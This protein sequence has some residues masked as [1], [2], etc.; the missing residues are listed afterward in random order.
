M[1][2]PP[3]PPINTADL[4]Q[5][6]RNLLTKMTIALGAPGLIAAIEFLTQ[7]T[8]RD[9][10]DW[11]APFE[12]FV[13]KLL[14]AEAAKLP[15][16]TDHEP[17]KLTEL[18][19]GLK[20]L[21]QL[22]NPKPQ[23][24]QTPRPPKPAHVV[25]P[26]RPSTWR[27]SFALIIPRDRTQHR[28][29]NRFDNLRMRILDLGSPAFFAEMWRDEEERLKY[30]AKMAAK[31]KRKA[32]RARRLAERFEA[33][34]RVIED[35]A[36]HVERLAAKIWRRRAHA[37]W[38]ARRLA[39]QKSPRRCRAFPNDAILFAEWLAQLAIAEFLMAKPFPVPEALAD[40]S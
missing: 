39:T 21:D 18:Q 31:E 10:L 22:E 25:E 33:L 4:W 20:R 28:P 29:S 5:I 17:P 36:R 16:P 6:A 13:R 19:R 11:L 3:E 30:E 8:R 27:V 40:S 35:P 15:R 23:P 32:N 37:A 14:L 26:N 34:R 2:Q 1:T 9:I 12:L 24:P 38:K 7:R